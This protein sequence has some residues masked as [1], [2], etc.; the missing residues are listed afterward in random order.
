MMFVLVNGRL[1]VDHGK[2][3]RQRIPGAPRV[4]GFSD[5]LMVLSQAQ[6]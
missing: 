2:L 6:P 5:T 1:I 4:F 3:V